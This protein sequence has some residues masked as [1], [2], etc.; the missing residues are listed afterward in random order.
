M[1]HADL[2]YESGGRSRARTILYPGLSCLP[3]VFKWYPLS[4]SLIA[5]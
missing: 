3:Y 2:A 1:V 5:A 4:N